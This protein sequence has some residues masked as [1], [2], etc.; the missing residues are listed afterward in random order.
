MEKWQ[1]SLQNAITSVPELLKL[2]EIPLAFHSNFL[3]DKEF[4]LLVTQEFFQR[5]QKKDPKDPLFLQIVPQ[6]RE[7]E[8]QKKFSKDP[9][10]EIAINPVPGLLHR[11]VGRVLLTLTGACP[12]HCRF[13]FRRHF[14]YT[15]NNPLKTNFEQIF[16]YIKN[17]QSIE[18][19]IYSGGDPLLVNDRELQ[20]ISHEFTKIPHIKRLR[21]HTRVP[22]FLPSRINES[23][24]SWLS[25]YPLSVT[26]VIHCNHPREIDAEVRASLHRLRPLCQLL[27]QAVLLQSVNDD[28]AILKEL[29]TQLFETGVLPY[30]IHRLDLVHG[31]KH[32][33]VSLKKSKELIREL[34]TQLPGYLVPRLVKTQ[35]GAQHKIGLLG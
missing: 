10:K 31:A 34:A 22:I 35:T 25:Q 1:N 12:V 16:N 32:F 28:V 17:D 30:Y 11:Y 29:S 9:L 5:I 24:V 7:K 6:V 19:I 26:M 13:C 20:K 33:S 8:I 4:P 14:P 23:F 18:E 2:L 21:F 27:N 15:K 3:E